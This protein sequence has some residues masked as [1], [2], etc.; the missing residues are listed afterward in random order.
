M[1]GP[2]KATPEFE[3]LYELFAETRKVFSRYWER[4]GELKGEEVQFLATVTLSHIDDI[5]VGFKWVLRAEQTPRSELRYLLQ[6]GD[7]TDW[8]DEPGGAPR[9]PL[10]P[11]LRKVMALRHAQVVFG[12]LPRTPR[13]EISYPGYTSYADIK[14]P[15]SPLELRERIEELARG[16][17]D[18]ATNRPAGSLDPERARRVYGFFEAGSWLTTSHMRRIRRRN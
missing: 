18:A 17:W 13:G 9:E 14:V 12:C 2:E 11:D 6:P 8:S 16:V 3:K 1:L 4:N 10:T 7:V 15:R 5:D